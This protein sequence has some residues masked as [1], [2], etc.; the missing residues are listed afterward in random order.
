MDRYSDYC[1]LFN[2]DDT[3]TVP[4]CTALGQWVGLADNPDTIT[5]LIDMHERVN[6]GDA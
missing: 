1:V 4:V 5:T 2:A 6:G 3:G